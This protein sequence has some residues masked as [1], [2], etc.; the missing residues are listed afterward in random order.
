M[1]KVQRTLVVKTIKYKTGQRKDFQQPQI[2]DQLRQILAAKRAVGDL[3][4]PA[5]PKPPDPEDTRRRWFINKEVVTTRGILFQ[6]C[7]FIPGDV[8][9]SVDLDFSGAEVA[10]DHQP[11]TGDDGKQRQVVYVA[12][13]LAYGEILVIDSPKGTGGIQGLETYLTNLWRQHTADPGFPRMHLEDSATKQLRQAIAA[14]GGATAVELSMREPQKA[15]DRRFAK[16]MSSAQRSIGGTE[17]V[18]IRW[19]SASTLGEDAI[20]EAYD[21]ADSTDAIDGITIEL[22]NG[23]RIRA[24]NYKLRQPLA[25]TT[26]PGGA[27]S[28]DQIYTELRRYLSRLISSETVTEDGKLAP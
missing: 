4:L 5:L 19:E 18:V 7:S 6:C 2:D 25:I 23:D 28:A 27:V 1:P 9:P 15:G 17:R 26:G 3:V 14:G 22:K 11:L 21:E 13:V 8:P 12:H 16:T 10:V 24:G 20:Q